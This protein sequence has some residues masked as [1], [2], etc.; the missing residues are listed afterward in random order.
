MPCII[1]GAEAEIPLAGKRKISVAP[2]IGI[3][4]APGFLNG[5]RSEPQSV[6]AAINQMGEPGTGVFDELRIG[7]A[8]RRFRVV[9]PSRDP[10][11]VAGWIPIV[12]PHLN[13]R[14]GRAG[15]LEPGKDACFTI[16]AALDF[17]DHKCPIVAPASRSPQ[18]RRARRLP[19]GPFSR[20]S[21][22]TQV[23]V[24][25]FHAVAVAMA[26]AS[27]LFLVFRNVRDHDFGREH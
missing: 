23:L 20:L 27:G 24:H 19:A 18:T 4:K 26:A 5:D 8:H 10:I 25:P 16:F 6:D 22:S 14:S 13:D 2:L 21:L 12:Q 9:A 15:L 3:R 1:S 17:N 7:G 11:P